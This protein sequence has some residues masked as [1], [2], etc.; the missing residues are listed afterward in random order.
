MNDF[1]LKPMK[2][3]QNWEAVSLITSPLFKSSGTVFLCGRYL[4]YETG[5]PFLRLL[6]LKK[7]ATNFSLEF[8]LSKIS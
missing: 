5:K 3:M 6:Y 1:V 7:I 2:L 4:C 8:E